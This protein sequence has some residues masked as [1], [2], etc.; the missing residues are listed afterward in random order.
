M[1][2]HSIPATV[3]KTIAQIETEVETNEVTST[4][5]IIDITCKI[6]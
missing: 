5:W 6:H 2:V 4:K 3:H 1:V